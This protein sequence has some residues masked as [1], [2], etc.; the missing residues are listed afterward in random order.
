MVADFYRSHPEKGCTVEEALRAN[1]DWGFEQPM[2]V[3]MELGRVDIV[4]KL[5]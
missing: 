3:A 2:Y 1:D 4:Q 5:V